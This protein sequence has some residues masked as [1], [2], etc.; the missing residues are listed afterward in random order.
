MPGIKDNKM[1]TD[2]QRKEREGGGEE[3]KG[4]KRYKLKAAM[5]TIL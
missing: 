5:K 4:D 1:Q 3:R 2:T